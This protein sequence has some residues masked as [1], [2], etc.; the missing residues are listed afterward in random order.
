WLVQPYTAPLL[1]H[2]PDVNQVIVDSGGPL[3]E[4]TER[5]RSEH[6]DTAIVAFPRW[7]A[8]WATWR[9]GIP[10]RVGPASKFYT[11]LFSQ[12]VWQRRSE[13]KKHEADYNLELLEPL[14]IP[15]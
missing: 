12:R 13:G 15:F 4:L 14:G 1:D 2:N 5:L 3:R 8:V 10:T 7:R 9:A 11:A 6:F